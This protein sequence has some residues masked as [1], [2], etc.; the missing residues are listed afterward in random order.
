MMPPKTTSKFSFY[1]SLVSALPCTKIGA[2][3]TALPRGGRGHIREVAQA[4]C[5]DFALGLDITPNPHRVSR[6]F[7]DAEGN[8]VRIISAG[9]GMSCSSPT[10]MPKTRLSH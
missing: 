9:R 8:L 3:E 6:N 2:A 4:C 1:L 10:W 5:K 7:L